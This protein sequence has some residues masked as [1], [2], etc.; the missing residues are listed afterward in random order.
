M[1]EIYYVL[2]SIMFS[3]NYQDSS[4]TIHVC[5]LKE[6][7]LYYFSEFGKKNK[8]KMSQCALISHVIWQV[9]IDIVIQ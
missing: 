1:P 6:L 2:R 7:E 3:H 8:P 9:N 4:G 5:Y